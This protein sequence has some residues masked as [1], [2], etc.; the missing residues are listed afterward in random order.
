MT[1][2][3]NELESD[4]LFENLIELT[5]LYFTTNSLF[6]KVE[7]FSDVLKNDLIKEYQYV[8]NNLMSYLS[9]LGKNELKESN[10]FYLQTTHA[11]KILYNDCVDS[12]LDIAHT[13]ILDLVADTSGYNIAISEFYPDYYKIIDALENIDKERSISRSFGNDWNQRKLVYDKIIN[14]NDFEVIIGFLRDFRKIDDSKRI[15]IKE[16]IKNQ[17]REKRD[18]VLL[19]ATIIGAFVGVISLLLSFIK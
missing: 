14:S 9:S 12:I 18:L 5:D 3:K 17:K 4:D 1:D 11:V 6:K 10:Q 8:C 2:N 19:F 16:Y 7:N 15:A 13:K